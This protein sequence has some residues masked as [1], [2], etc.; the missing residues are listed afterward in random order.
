MGS[1]HTLYTFENGAVIDETGPHA[2]YNVEEDSYL[3][4]SSWKI[5]YHTLDEFN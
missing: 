4:L 2:F 3:A 1:F 5:G